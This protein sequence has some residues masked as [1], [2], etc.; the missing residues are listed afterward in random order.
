MKWGKHF[1]FLVN[2]TLILTIMLVACTQSNDYV[3]LSAAEAKTAL[4]PCS[5]EKILID[6]A[7]QLN[8][9]DILQLE[10][11]FSSL[12]NLESVDCC[13]QGKIIGVP[14]DYFR[15]YLGVVINSQ[16]YI[17]INAFSKKT[18]KLHKKLEWACDGGKLFWGAFYSPAENKF[19]HLAFNG[20]VL[21]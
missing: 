8:S 21:K 20:S 15:Q 14:S 2:A 18:S 6:A 11:N 1:I 19:S 5:R 16:K 7:W 10:K 12:L 13:D 4:I 3:V 9:E 17:Y